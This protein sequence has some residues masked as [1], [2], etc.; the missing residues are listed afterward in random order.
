MADQHIICYHKVD[1]NYK[2]LSLDIQVIH[3]N[4]NE[5]ENEKWIN[6]KIPIKLKT[7]SA[8]IPDKEEIEVQRWRIGV[9][10]FKDRWDK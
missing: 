9:N 6:I 10:K 4:E 8:C 3:L 5:C 7:Q 1:L 2:Q